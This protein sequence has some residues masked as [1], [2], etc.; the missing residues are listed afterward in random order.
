MSV[1]QQLSM[2]KPNLTFERA[3]KLLAPQQGKNRQGSEYDTRRT[4]HHSVS[5]ITIK[6]FKKS[7]RNYKK[8]EY[9][10]RS[11]FLPQGQS[12]DR[13]MALSIFEASLQ[14]MNII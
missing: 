8:Q 5:I 4:C 2:L 1:T 13:T 10:A 6:R 14:R 9:V 11:H 3:L 12:T 7:L